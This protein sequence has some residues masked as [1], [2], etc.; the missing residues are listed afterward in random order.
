MSICGIL[1]VVGITLVI[2]W[3]IFLFVRY[4]NR[5]KA[6]DEVH[7]KAIG[8]VKIF[9]NYLNSLDVINDSF[10]KNRVISEVSSMLKNFEPNLFEH[11]DEILERYQRHYKEINV[12]VNKYLAELNDIEKKIVKNKDIWFKDDEHIPFFFVLK[13]IDNISSIFYCHSTN[14]HIKDKDTGLLSGIIFDSVKKRGYKYDISPKNYI[15][16]YMTEDEFEGIYLPNR[17]D[18]CGF[19]DIRESNEYIKFLREEFKKQ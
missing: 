19:S 3:F 7:S 9:S 16:E 10:W 11:D 12:L 17:V 6:I 13:P 18:V 14:L 2:F 15:V 5:L 8:S 4:K 1:V